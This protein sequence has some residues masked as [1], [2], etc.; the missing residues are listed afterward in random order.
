MGPERSWCVSDL[1]SHKRPFHACNGLQPS[2]HNLHGGGFWGCRCANTLAWSGIPGGIFGPR[3]TTFLIGREA[4][5][6]A[7]SC[8]AGAVAIHMT[9][10]CAYLI[11]RWRGVLEGEWAELFVLWPAVL[12]LGAWHLSSL[13]RSAILLRHMMRCAENEVAK[14]GPRSLQ[15]EVARQRV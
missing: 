13:T 7:S 9:H 3:R 11:W 4:G 8:P 6:G 12:H 10:T 1:L 15:N 2:Q 5:R 14:S